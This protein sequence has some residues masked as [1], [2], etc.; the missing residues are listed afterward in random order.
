MN[1]KEQKVVARNKKALHDYFIE[2]RYEAGLALRGTEVKSVRLGKVSIKESYAQIVRGEVFVFG[3]HISPYEHGNIYNVDPL[4][5][6][7][8]LLHRK[9]IRK[10]ETQVMQ[11][12]FTLVPLSIYIRDG[13][14]KLELGLARGKKL[15][16]KRETLAKKDEMRRIDREMSRRYRE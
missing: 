13:L 8:L 4:R 10:L 15:Y 1:K 16:D 2:E 11:K 6:R 5:T 3:M 7:K 14:V 12:G 9:Q